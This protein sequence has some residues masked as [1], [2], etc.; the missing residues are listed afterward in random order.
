MLLSSVFHY[1]TVIFLLL[2]APIRALRSAGSGSFEVGSPSRSSAHRHSL[3]KLLHDDSRSSSSHSS[4][5][6]TMSRHA[7]L[8][9]IEKDRPVADISAHFHDMIFVP[10]HHYKQTMAALEASRKGKQVASSSSGST[11]L[12]LFDGYRPSQRHSPPTTSSGPV[13]SDPSLQSTSR[14]WSAES[15]ERMV[16][17][18][19]HK[20]RKPS[21]L[22]SKCQ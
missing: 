20:V 2:S 22:R 16:K 9:E 14:K 17:S 11:G 6:W 18:L 7:D 5:E 13:G 19:V 15:M 4:Q 21:C 10:S 3:E 1:K 8:Q 12:P